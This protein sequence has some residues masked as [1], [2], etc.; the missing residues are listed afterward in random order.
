[1]SPGQTPPERVTLARDFLA[2]AKRRRVADLPVAVLMREDA[3]LRRILGEMLTLLADCEDD[4]QQRAATHVTA[5]GG[6]YLVPGD[7]VVLGFALGE[8]IGQRGLRSGAY[9]S[10]ARVLG[11]EVPR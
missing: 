9:L 4:E 2:A 6:A 1:M 3:E 5:D 7:V 10:L 8:A 11:I